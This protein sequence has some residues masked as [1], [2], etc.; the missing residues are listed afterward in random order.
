MPEW[1]DVNDLPILEP[2]SDRDGSSKSES[3]D[4]DI[5]SDSD[6]DDAPIGFTTAPTAVATKPIVATVCYNLNAFFVN[7]NNGKAVKPDTAYKHKHF[8]V[9]AIA[10]AVDK[11]TQSHE[12]ALLATHDFVTKKRPNYGK[13][14]GL[15]E[16]QVAEG[17]LPFGAWVG[18]HYQGL[19]G[20]ASS[21]T[22]QE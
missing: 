12:Q 10:E 15:L 9:K 20:Q 1:S 13:T 14:L 18:Q 11:H 22:Q 21:H 8:A 16:Y 3:D 17:N 6:H 2:R 19:F 5:E 4:G 7:P